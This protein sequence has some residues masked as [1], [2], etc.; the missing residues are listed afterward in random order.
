MKKLLMFLVSFASVKAMALS[1]NSSWAQIF[2]SRDAFVSVA[3]DSL[4][5]IALSN[6][7]ISG[8]NI[9]TIKDVPVCI[10]T[11]AV[12]VKVPDGGPYTEYHCVE[13]ANQKIVNA[14]TYQH[15]Y[16]QLPTPNGEQEPDPSK[17]VPS[18]DTITTPT[19]VSAQVVENHGE[20]PTTFNKDFTFPT[21]N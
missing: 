16:C 3:Y 18:V 4:N 7:C 14:R 17:C 12:V 6:A 2:A 19:T 8:D 1:P 11:V 5:G 13:Y 9:E 15:K 21:C 20:A 10:K